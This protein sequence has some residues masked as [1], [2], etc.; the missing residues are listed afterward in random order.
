MHID[1][2]KID[3]QMASVFFEIKRKLPYEE[4]QQLKISSPDVGE[5]LI[6][7]YMASKSETVKSLILDFMELAGNQWKERLVGPKP[8]SLFSFSSLG[9]WQTS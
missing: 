1:R 2:L 9:A 4:R 3:R 8:K 7:I 6:E 5:Q